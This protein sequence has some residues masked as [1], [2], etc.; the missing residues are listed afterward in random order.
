[1]KK[2]GIALGIVIL[3]SSL[4]SCVGTPEPTV[5]MSPATEVSVMMA[6]VDD[7]TVAESMD[8][9][10]AATDDTWDEPAEA[11]EATTEFDDPSTATEGEMDATSA[12]SEDW[13]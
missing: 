11:A 3:L 2:L 5:E 12:A 8:A 4:A 13:E 7:S 9:T 1:M 6:P 10:S